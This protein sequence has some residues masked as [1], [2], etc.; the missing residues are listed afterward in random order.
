MNEND[1]QK[2]IQAIGT[3]AEMALCFYKAVIGAGGTA[4]EAVSLSKAMMQVLLVDILGTA[5]KNKKAEEK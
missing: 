3:L 5:D 4:E 2:L 1:V